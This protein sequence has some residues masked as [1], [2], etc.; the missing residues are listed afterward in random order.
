MK[1]EFLV[2]EKMSLKQAMKHMDA[3]GKKALFI[4]D[5][6]ERLLGSLSD[7][8]IRRWILAGGDLSKGV[9]NASNKNPISVP[10]NYDFLKIKQLML[11]KRIEYIPVVNKEK[12]VVKVLL[13]DEIFAGRAVKIKK[14]LNIPVVIMAGGKGTR[15]DPFT[16]ILPKPLIP[17]KG[18]P[19]I[20]I[21]MDKF[22]EYQID[23]FYVSINHQSRMVKAYFS[24][25]KSKY[26]INYLEETT[27]LGTAGSL[28]FIADKVKG[29]LIVSNCD[30]IIESDYHEILAYHRN[31][32]NDITI[33][34][35]YRQYVIPYGVCKIENG[36][37]LK[38]ITEKPAY[39]FL[40]NT[41]FC[42]LQADVLQYIPENKTY[43]MTD[44]VEKVKNEGGQVGVYP[45]S[46]NSW[47]DIGQWEE[48]K[49][50]VEKFKL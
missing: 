13:W 47:V 45:I 7:G 40:V 5:V 28:G 10:E 38:E 20:K 26:E 39:D 9:L 48:Y 21:I 8:D 41:G 30:I 27:P 23:K 49:K 22:N 6:K 31:S 2:T 17:I 35:A 43:Y 15:L 16:K 42:I 44:L 11:N 25:I 14:K 1:Q 37:R 3:I 18:E 29:A 19:I 12:Q 50:V 4:I 32:N 24:D 46:E 33:V 34:G 36:G